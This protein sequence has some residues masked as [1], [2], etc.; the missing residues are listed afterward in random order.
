V[1]GGCVGHN[2]RLGSGLIIYP[3]RT[4]E[5]DTILVASAE[6][7]VITKNVTYEESDHHKWPGGAELHPRLYDPD[8]GPL[9]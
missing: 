7:H 6:R 3:A 5:S 8:A 1:M 4:I 2:C 9:L